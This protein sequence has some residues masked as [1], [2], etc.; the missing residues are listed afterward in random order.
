MNYVTFFSQQYIKM[1]FGKYGKVTWI[2]LMK[3]F[4]KY[5]KFQDLQVKDNICEKT[6]KDIDYFPFVHLIVNYVTLNF[7]T[8]PT[9]Y[10]LQI[11]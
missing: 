3:R 9:W 8:I 5:G 2:N 6:F 4:P 1:N 11:P 7:Y 10:K